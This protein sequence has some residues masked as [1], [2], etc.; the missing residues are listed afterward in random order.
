MIFISTDYTV[1]LRNLVLRVA[2]FSEVLTIPLKV[3]RD[4]VTAHEEGS[5]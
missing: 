3:T 1:S 4:S 2:V 5:K